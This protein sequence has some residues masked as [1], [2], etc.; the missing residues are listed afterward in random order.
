MTLTASKALVRAGFL[1]LCFEGKPSQP[2]NELLKGRTR[3]LNDL[4]L[5]L[6][7]TEWCSQSLMASL[8]SNMTVS[9][10]VMKA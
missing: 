6:E 8:S 4:A 2:E 9:P 3:T 1:G 10:H 7:L 5:A